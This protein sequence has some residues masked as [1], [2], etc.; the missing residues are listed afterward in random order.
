MLLLAEY[1]LAELLLNLYELYT[2]THKVCLAKLLFNL[3]QLLT[4]A[5]KVYLVKL[6][7]DSLQPYCVI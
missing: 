5:Y 2:I 4:I 3:Y 1:I 7:P 6:L